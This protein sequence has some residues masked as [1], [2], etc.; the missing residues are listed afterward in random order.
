MFFQADVGKTAVKKF[1]K[2]YQKNV[3]SSVPFKKFKL[4]NTPTYNYVKTDSA[5]IISLFAS[6]IL[7]FAC[8]GIIFK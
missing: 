7:K 8:G 2:N 1:F 6:I 5:T 3:F 4:S